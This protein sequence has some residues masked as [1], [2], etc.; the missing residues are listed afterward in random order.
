MS[1]AGDLYGQSLYDL[2]AEENLTDEILGEMEVVKGIFKDNP[3]YVT[4]LSEPSVPKNERLQLVDKAFDGSL[5]P[6]LM[7][8]IKILIEKGLLREFSACYKR[9]RKSYN[10]AHGIA[11]ALVTTAVKLSDSQL[12]GLSEKLEKISGKK[13]LLEQKVD[14]N[15]LGGVRVDLEGQLFDGTVKGRLSELRRRVDEVVL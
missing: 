7:N 2:A 6:Y 3:D 10:D 15:V 1:K 8:F 13:I 12:A 11:D 5:Q 14:A 9:F 4:L